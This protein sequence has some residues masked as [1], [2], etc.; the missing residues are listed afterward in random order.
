MAYPRLRSMNAELDAGATD[1]RWKKGVRDRGGEVDPLTMH[2]RDELVPSFYDIREK[3]PVKDVPTRGDRVVPYYT[4][5]PT[6]MYTH[7]S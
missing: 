1:G 5:V 7:L 4:E 2:M 3:G 6:P